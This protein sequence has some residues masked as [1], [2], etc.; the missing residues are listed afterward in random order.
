[1]IRFSPQ[2]DFIKNI[3]LEIFDLNLCK[4]SKK[5]PGISSKC[6]FK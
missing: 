3:D 4:S 1:L 6:S 5:D 2:R